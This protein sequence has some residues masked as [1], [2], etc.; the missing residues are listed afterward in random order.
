V[1]SLVLAALSFVWFGRARNDNLSVPSVVSFK[2]R[3]IARQ[4]FEQQYGR[5]ADRM[6]VLSWLAEWYLTRKNLQNAVLCFQEIPT[7]HPSYGHMARFQQGRTLL[8]L[9]R[10]AEAETQFRELIEAEE[11]APEIEPKYL[12]DAR[13]RLRHILEVELRFEER[14]SLLAG[15]VERGEA[16]NFETVAYCFPSHLRWNGLQ[17]LEWIQE[18]YATDPAQPAIRVA[19]GRYLTGQGKL[20]ESQRILQDVVR[21]FPTD[22]RAIA[23]LIAC[24]RE[25]DN[26]QEA[27]R[28]MSTVAVRPARESWLMLQQRGEIALQHGQS[29]EALAAYEL[30][31]RGDRTCTA[32]WQGLAN[33]ARLSGDMSKRNA[34][35]KMVGGLGRIQ[36]HLGKII[37]N[38]NDSNAFLDI[39]DLC[40]EIDLNREGQILAQ[41]VVRLEPRN[42]RAL[43]T[44]KLF[45][46]RPQAAASDCATD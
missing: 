4:S 28:L 8:I 44:A 36:N 39:A 13:Q 9:H 42:R 43:D 17:A 14:Q 38:A 29:G 11:A 15:V 1:A 2:E 40:A 32:A 27:D 7:S 16:D 22:L 25:A 20:Q 33:A 18:F 26:S 35:L 12:I 34:A 24:F 5:I 46:A 6:D 30:W 37:R 10:A 3:E 45:Q 21:E 23:A 41:F 31:I 19:L